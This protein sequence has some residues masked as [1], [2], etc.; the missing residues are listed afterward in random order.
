MKLDRFRPANK[1]RGDYSIL[2]VSMGLC[3]LGLLLISSASVVK[4]YEEFGS[5][6]VYLLKQTTFLVIGLIAMIATSIIDYRIWQKY[7]LY[8]LIGSIFLVLAVHLPFGISISGAR[9]WIEIG[10]LLFQPSELMKLSFIIYLSAW[11]SSRGKEITSFPKGIFPVGVL[12]GLIIILLISQKDLGTTLVI[13]TIGGIMVFLSGALLTHISIGLVIGLFIFYGL[14]KLESYRW[15][16]L[17]TFLN[18]TADLQGAGYQINQALIAIGSGGLWGLGFGQSIQKYLYIPQVQ[19]DMIFAIMAEELGYIRVSLILLAIL[20]LIFK[21][22]S[23]AKSTSDV[24]GKLVCVGIG[25]WILVQTFYNIA[26]VMGIIPLTGIPIP[27]L[28]YGGSSL[29]VLLMGMGI[30]YNISRSA[31]K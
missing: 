1:R 21:I 30:V 3:L 19:T 17:L 18:P 16:R 23:I 24:F 14:I 7:A 9:R 8:I 6:N 12:I 13:T 2:L 25:S 29:L 4:S 27:F 26:G 28:S 20:F 22:F 10:P 5:N 11:L 31:Q 15:Q